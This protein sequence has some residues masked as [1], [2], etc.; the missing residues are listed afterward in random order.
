MTENP[1]DF[2]PI[3][4]ILSAAFGFIVGDLCGD[5]RLSLIHI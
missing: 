4:M 3:W 2:I 5:Y 1:A